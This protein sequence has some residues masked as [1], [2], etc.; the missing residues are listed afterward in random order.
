M[1][2]Q[3]LVNEK[4]S[5]ISALLKQDPFMS[6]VEIIKIITKQFGTGIS[7]LEISQIRWDEHG[8]RLGPGGMAIDKKGHRVTKLETSSAPM[9]PTGTPP[10]QN[11]FT[12]LE[13][14]QARLAKLVRDLQAEMKILHVGQLTVPADGQ[15]EAVQTVRRNFMAAR[16]SA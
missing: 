7:R 11:A 15:A 13:E 14:S 4:H 2:T 5:Q 8:L 9:P 12:L 16:P 6:P 3:T 10:K 1:S